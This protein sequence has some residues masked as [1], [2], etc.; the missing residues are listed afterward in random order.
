[1]GLDLEGGVE[2]HEA[3]GV[4]GSFLTEPQNQT[5]KDVLSNGEL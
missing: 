4:G 2:F 5:L 1:M 3:F